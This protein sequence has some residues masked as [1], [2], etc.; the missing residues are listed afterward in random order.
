MRERSTPALQHTRIRA[1][2]HTHA[3]T[4]QSTKHPERQRQ[5]VLTEL[6]AVM[7]LQHHPHAVQLLDAYEDGRGYH[8]VMPMLKGV[9]CLCVCACVRCTTCSRR[10]RKCCHARR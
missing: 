9:S 6:G 7:R 1:C 2:T 5:R 10:S 8:L 3:R 4:Q